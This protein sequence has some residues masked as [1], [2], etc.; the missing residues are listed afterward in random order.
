MADPQKKALAGTATLRAPK[1]VEKR[2]AIWKAKGEKTSKP[3][4]ARGALHQPTGFTLEQQKCQERGVARLRPEIPRDHSWFTRISRA[5]Q[6]VLWRTCLKGRYDIAV[7]PQRRNARSARESAQAGCTIAT[8]L[9]FTPRSPLHPTTGDGATH[10]VVGVT[11]LVGS[12]QVRSTSM[13][14]SSEKSSSAAEPPALSSH[15]RVS[16][17]RSSPSDPR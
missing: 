12:R 13:S 17:A 4:R 5:F 10:R 15:M 1:L 3:S 16:N 2:E 6:I 11:P 9:R 14:I 8:H 7:G